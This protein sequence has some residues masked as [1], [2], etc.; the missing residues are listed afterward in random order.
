[1]SEPESNELSSEFHSDVEKSANEYGSIQGS[2]SD[3]NSEKDAA[4][5]KS[6]S[7]KR[8]K[9]IVNDLL[10]KHVTEHIHSRLNSVDG[11]SENERETLL[12]EYKLVKDYKDE[13]REISLFKGDIVEIV[14]ISKAEKWLVR[15]KYANLIQVC[16]VPPDILEKMEAKTKLSSEAASRKKTQNRKTYHKI[17]KSEKILFGDSI[18]SSQSQIRTIC[19]NFDDSNTIYTKAGKAD[20]LTKAGSNTSLGAITLIDEPIEVEQPISSTVAVQINEVKTTTKVTEITMVKT[21]KY[22]SSAKGLKITESKVTDS[23]TIEQKSLDSKVIEAKKYESKG[24]ELKATEVTKFE[25]KSIDI[26]AS[27]VKNSLFKGNEFTSSEARSMETNT[28]VGSEKSTKYSI[29][30]SLGKLDSKLNSSLPDLGKFLYTFSLCMI[31]Y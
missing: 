27:E 8:N 24:V 19:Y 21:K 12:K 4:A 5:N 16:Y 29:D 6:L 3:N 30:Q 1:M 18:G 14:D 28:I 15:S 20:T 22:D 2:V 25:T 9:E 26:K 31:I 17:P 11:H 13:E 10:E 23:K 7:E